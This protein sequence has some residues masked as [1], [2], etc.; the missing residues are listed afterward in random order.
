VHQSGTGILNVQ[1]CYFGAGTTAVAVQMDTAVAGSSIGISN[2]F[3]SMTLAGAGIAA[4]ETISIPVTFAGAVSHTAAVSFGS[5]T[6]A[7]NRTVNGPAGAVRQ[8]IYSTAGSTRWVSMVN[9]TAEGGS[10]AGSDFAIQNF[11]D[12]GTFKTNALQ[13]ARSSGS[14]TIPGGV[15]HGTAFAPGGVTDL[16][17]HI[18]L[19]ST[20]FGLSVTS[21]R[22]NLVCPS[23]SGV[24]FN[25][26]GT[27]IASFTTTAATFGNDTLAG[28]MNINLDTAAGRYRQFI[29]QT[30]G[31]PRWNL[32]VDNSAESGSN[33]GSN[34]YIN[35]YSDAGA[36]LGT[37]LSINRA[38]GG[39]TVDQLNVTT[40]AGPNIR[41][42]AGAATGTQPAGSLWLRTDG[43]AGARLYVSAGGGTWAA[44]AGV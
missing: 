12:A 28:N 4:A 15:L 11:S 19:Y 37:P 42:G 18:A 6:A 20:T 21:A 39:V 10:D 13:I 3:N 30:A 7:V 23:G 22:L 40:A 17:K 24:W 43:S 1:H 8:T 44:V 5:N 27:D 29:Y 25:A 26:G 33:A 31:S 14:V 9:S 2:T 38:A 36:N 41:S 32:Q 34:L 35:R 16:S